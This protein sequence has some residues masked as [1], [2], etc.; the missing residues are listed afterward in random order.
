M[1]R[2]AGDNSGTGGQNFGNFL[3]CQARLVR[4]TGE[5]RAEWRVWPGDRDH[6]HAARGSPTWTNVTALPLL[7]V[8]VLLGLPLLVGGRW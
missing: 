6:R 4:L 8:H 2:K 7:L 5:E 1:D 3:G